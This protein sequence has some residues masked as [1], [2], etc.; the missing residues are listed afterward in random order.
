MPRPTR[1]AEDAALGPWS[2]SRPGHRCGRDRYV[3][4]SLDDDAGGL[5]AI[6]AN[7]GM[8][9]VAGALDAETATSHDITMRATQ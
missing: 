5:F 7:T 6:D 9:T 3:T 1:V 2:A 4:Y 8:V